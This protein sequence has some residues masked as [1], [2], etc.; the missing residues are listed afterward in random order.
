MLKQVANLSDSAIASES[1]GGVLCEP[2]NLR[3]GVV[4]CY[5]QANHFETAKIVN[6]VAD[7]SDFR[8]VDPVFL[9]DAPQLGPFIFYAVDAAN[10]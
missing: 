9:G 8:K 1:F 4:D 3:I 6:V 7:E 5:W 2:Q 10:I